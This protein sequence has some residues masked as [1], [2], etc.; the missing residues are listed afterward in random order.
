MVHAGNFYYLAKI[1]N[2]VSFFSGENMTNARRNIND[3][4]INAYEQQRIAIIA[5]NKRKLASLNI[6][7]LKTAGPSEKRTKVFSK[8]QV[9]CT[10]F[11]VI[12]TTSWGFFVEDS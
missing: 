1:A 12:F 7:T 4:P 3:A 8:L 10:F 9:H 6:P 11:M 5:E 2:L